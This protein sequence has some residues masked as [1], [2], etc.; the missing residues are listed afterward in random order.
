M[1]DL[2]LS[3]T[4]STH[5]TGRSNEATKNWQFLFGTLTE[6]KTK[7]CFFRNGAPHNILRNILCFTIRRRDAEDGLHFL[8]HI[9]HLDFLDLDHLIEFKCSVHQEPRHFFNI[10]LH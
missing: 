1:S 10:L 8:L 5:Y 9:R 2:R 6:P 7:T 4:K 3:N